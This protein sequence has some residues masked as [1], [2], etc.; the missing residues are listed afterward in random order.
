MSGM[1]FIY[2]EKFKV[3]AV[4]VDL[5]GTLID[6]TLIYFKIIKIVFDKL[7]IPSVS[8]KTILNAI[9]NGGFEWDVVLPHEMLDRKEEFIPKAQEI[10]NDIGPK[11]FQQEV[12]LIPGAGE[13]LRK[14]FSAG[15][16]IGMVTSTSRENMKVKI[17]PLRKAGIEKMLEVVIT[18]DDVQKRKPAPDPLVAC[19]EK[20]GVAMDQCVYVGDTCADIKAGKAAGMKTI[21]VLSGFDNYESLKKESPDAIINSVVE[22]H[23]IIK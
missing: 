18:T 16:K 10:I 11:L 19:G 4:I 8:R 15:K 22:L 21:G 9:K 23:E 7:R 6:S 13:I 12:K 5:D 1:K 20:L 17:E 14:F 2:H 3:E